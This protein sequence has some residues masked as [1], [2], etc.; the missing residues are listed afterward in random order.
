MDR[1]GWGHDLPTRATPNGEMTGSRLHPTGR[2]I[3]VT[4]QFRLAQ[5]V[6]LRRRI[7]LPSWAETL[8]ENHSIT[9]CH[10]RVTCLRVSSNLPA[11]SMMRSARARFA[12]TGSCACSR[13]SKSAEVQPRRFARASRR[14]RGASTKTSLLHNLSQPASRSNGASSTATGQDCSARASAWRPKCRK[15]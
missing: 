10:S 7:T 6:V 12:S 1:W 13:A 14:S 8:T 3:P 11:F 4:G 9:D 5:G 15:S 2:E